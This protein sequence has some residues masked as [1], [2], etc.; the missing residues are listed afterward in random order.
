[1]DFMRLVEQM[2]S[3]KMDIFRLESREH[4]AQI[5]SVERKLL[6]KRFRYE[7]KDK[8]ELQ[9]SEGILPKRL[10]LLYCSPTMELGVDIASLNVVYMRNVP[11]TPANYAQRSG[12]AGRSGQPALVVSYCGAHS[13]HD[14]WFFEHQEQMVQGEV[15]PPNLDLM[16]EELVTSHIHSIWLGEID[17]DIPPKISEVLDMEEPGGNMP[18]IKP[19]RDAVNDP[20]TNNSALQMAKAFIDVIEI[21]GESPGWLVDNFAEQVIKESPEKFDKA[22]DRWRSLYSSTQ[23]QI[24]RSNE[25]TERLGGDPKEKSDAQRRAAEAISQQKVLQGSGSELNSDF[26]TYRYLANQVSYRGNSPDCH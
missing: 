8:E 12:R 22:F 16:N 1:M 5:D 7:T 10:P 25:I 9:N 15:A 17:F 3:G 21:T 18:L 13:P 20:K 19:I 14:R 4:T 6:E 26:N 23:E 11:P 24:K 2:Q